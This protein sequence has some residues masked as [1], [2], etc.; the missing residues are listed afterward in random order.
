MQI[1]FKIGS[2]VELRGLELQGTGTIIKIGR[3][4]ALVKLDAIPQCADA[5]GRRVR[6]KDEHD[7]FYKNLRILP[8]DAA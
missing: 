1:T 5:I 8:T 7:F 3:L 4:R 6:P 2:R